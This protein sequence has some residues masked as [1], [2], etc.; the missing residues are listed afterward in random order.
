MRTCAY[1][2]KPSQQMW[3]LDPRLQHGQQMR[4]MFGEDIRADHPDNQKLWHE[5][6]EKNPTVLFLFGFWQAVAPNGPKY[7]QHTWDTAW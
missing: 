2:R 4:L 3:N 6:N 5:N 7:M 1:V